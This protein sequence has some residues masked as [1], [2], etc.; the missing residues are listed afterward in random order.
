MQKLATI[1]STILHP[2]LMATYGCLLVFFGLSNS[3]YAV[4]T[5]FKTKIAIILMVFVF[6]FFIPVLNL[7]ILE[8][9]QERIFPLVMTAFCYFGLFYLIYDFNI[10]PAV[11]LF[12][13]GGGLCILLTAII[14]I[15]WQISAH[16]IGIGGVCGVLFAFCYYM[17][18]PVFIAISGSIMLAGI[19]GFARL[20]LRAHIPSQVYAGFII[21]CVMQFGLFGLAQLFRFL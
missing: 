13:L 7:F 20:Q 12:V 17:Q 16:L 15:W 21:G 10:W 4:Y 14:S 3:I 1:I 18:M 9:R 2:L 6:T 11:K 5:P 8:N 19:I